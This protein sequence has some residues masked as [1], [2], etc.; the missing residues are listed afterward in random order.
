[1]GIR[2]GIRKARG[3]RQSKRISKSNKRPAHRKVLEP[4]T[5]EW[6][7]TK[8]TNE[9]YRNIGLAR[10]LNKQRDILQNV[11]ETQLPLEV[12]YEVDINSIRALNQA[13]EPWNSENPKLKSLLKSA[14]QEAVVEKKKRPKLNREEIESL[15]RLL[16]KFRFDFEAMRKHIKLNVFQWTEI[17]CRNKLRAFIEKFGREKLVSIVGEYEDEEIFGRDLEEH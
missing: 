16:K 1:M 12:E 15:V 17:Q 10:D 2:S 9:N 11:P 13:N 5:Q 3:I 4:D 14:V 6:D 8:T 7:K